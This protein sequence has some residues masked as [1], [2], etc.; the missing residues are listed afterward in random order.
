MDDAAEPLGQQAAELFLDL[1]VGSD[2]RASLSHTRHI[3]WYQLIGTHAILIF[4]GTALKRGFQHENCEH[5]E[6]TAGKAP[7]RH[8]PKAWG[9]R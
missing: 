5:R 8:T 3:F 1:N 9:P 4:S 2:L 6:A 7:N